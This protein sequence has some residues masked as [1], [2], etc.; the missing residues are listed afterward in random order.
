VFRRIDLKILAVVGITVTLSLLL[1][2]I[3]YSDR[4]NANI[5][6]QN[7]RTMLNLI[8]STE[9]GLVTLMLSGYGDAGPVFAES[10]ERLG[11]LVNLRVLRND[12]MR[13]FTDNR[14]IREVN[15][16]LGYQQFELRDSEA[17]RVELPASNRAL[18][19]ALDSGAVVEYEDVTDDGERLM[20]LLAPISHV[21]SCDRCHADGA[22]H[23]GVIRLTTSLREVDASI[24]ASQ[25]QALLILFLT[26]LTIMGAISLFL[27]RTVIPPIRRVTEAMQHASAGNLRQQIQVPRQTELGTMARSF[28]FMTREL[29]AIYAGLDRERDKLT[30]IILGAQ[31]GIV[32][33][34]RTGQVVLV[35]P[36]TEPLL[37][38][39]TEELVRGGLHGLFDDPPW[40]AARLSAAGK[41]A[42]TD[43]LHYKGRVLSVQ[44][45]RIRNERDEPIGSAA[46]IRDIT[47]QHRL[48]ER[49]RNQSLTDPLTGLHNR[50]HF[51]ESLHA[52]FARAKR[53]ASPLALVFFDI[54]HFKRINDE[55]GHEQGD[56]ILQAVAEA[57][58]NAFRDIDILCRYGGE[59][60]TVLMPE[61][62]VTQACKQAEWARKTLEEL[63]V[64]GLQVTCS[65]GVAHYAGSGCPDAGT[66]LK[67]AD[68]A[69]YEAKQ[70]GRNQVRLHRPG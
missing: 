50:R 3:F 54:D 57:A 2:V 44:L 58:R 35:N 40:I 32:L 23:R 24:R 29:E 25:R 18:R 68:S 45:A 19:K 70:S 30:T 31:E 41:R 17:F 1:L 56:R 43:T 66:L 38:K 28:N 9:Q 4:E 15:A 59:E 48:Q 60:F 37:E 55:H 51:D 64:D 8:D 49:L 53:Y 7:R 67:R 65:F 13:A 21:P 46:L 33:T 52:E 62:D 47:Q 34:D 11:T 69:L 5:L 63:R 16:L 61:V 36:A 6:A 42:V 20:T 39:D 12:G 26:V 22:R 14:T 27:R 10:I